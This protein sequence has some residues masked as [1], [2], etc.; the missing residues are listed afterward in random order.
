MS[1]RS[2]AR[3]RASGLQ[4]RLAMRSRWLLGL[5]VAVVAASPACTEPVAPD[6][7][8]GGGD[9]KA[10]DPTTGFDEIDAAHTNRTFRNY[11]EAA[12]RFLERHDE[13]LARLTARSIRDRHVKVD[14][15]VDLT[16]WDFERVRA[17]LPDAG[18]TPDDW[19]RLQDR[20]SPVAAAI[21]AEIDGY[22]W[23]NRIYVA[24]G[25]TVSAL[26][27]TLVHEVNH[28]INRSEVGY[29]EDLP[30]SG[31]VHEYR[32]F[33]AESVITPEEYEGVDLVDYV[34]TNYE[35]DRASIDPAILAEPLA[36]T[37]LPDAE[38]WRVR[39]PAQDPVD[40]DAQCPALQ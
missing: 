15:L 18:L 17:D 2:L 33:Y 28:V 5:L 40:D 10:D 3:G 12:L 24:R 27:A 29:Y 8:D 6:E 35:L 21:R 7:L 16:C 22:M 31:F 14:E 30:T 39:A 4:L 23:S 37:L 34:I 32:S 38:A 36:P 26:A 20:G 13:E 11:I 25:L 19:H 9:G 1:A